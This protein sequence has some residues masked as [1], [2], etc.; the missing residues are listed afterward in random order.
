MN[1]FQQC[2][3]NFKQQLK[4]WNKSAFGNIFQ[5]QKEIECKLEDLQ[6]TLI[7]GSRTLDPV[8]EEE[9]LQA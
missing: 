5:R 9:K 1:K 6:R 2:L 4:S 7:S 8:K 3:K